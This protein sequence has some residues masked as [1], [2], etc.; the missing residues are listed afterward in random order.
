MRKV[1]DTAYAAVAAAAE[2]ES[3]KQLSANTAAILKWVSRH[4]AVAKLPATMPVRPKGQVAW[5]TTCALELERLVSGLPYPI[6]Y[7]TSMPGDTLRS[8]GHAINSESQLA[9]TQQHITHADVT[10]R[11]LYTGWTATADGQDGQI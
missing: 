7:L 11:D 4:K 2:P 9:V 1:P 3:T 5:I 6:A 10:L 8:F